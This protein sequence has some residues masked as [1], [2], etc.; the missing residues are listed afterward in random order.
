MFL[1]PCTTLVSW[2][3]CASVNITCTLKFSLRNFIHINEWEFYMWVFVG[4]LKISKFIFSKSPPYMF[5]IIFMYCEEVYFMELLYRK[6]Y[7]ILMKEFSRSRSHIFYHYI[8]NMGYIHY[9]GYKICPNMGNITIIKDNFN[10]T[11]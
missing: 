3:V 9:I 5:S 4:L 8:P 11:I 6:C 2:S 7:W 10:P 1:L